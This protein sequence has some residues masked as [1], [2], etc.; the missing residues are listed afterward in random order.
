MRIRFDSIGDIAVIKGDCIDSMKSN[1]RVILERNPRLRVVLAKKSKVDGL[2]RL[3]E[4][5]RIAG[6]N[7]TVTIHRENGCIFHI[8]LSLVHF[9]P[10]LAHERML[11]AM[12]VKDGE[13]VLNMFGGVGTFS[14]EIAKMVTAKVF[15]VDI[16]PD[17]VRLCLTNILSNYVRGGVTTILADA[18]ES[19]SIFPTHTFDRILLP[20]PGK[21]ID[22]LPLAI[23][24]LKS[25]GVIHLYEFINVSR[26]EDPVEG[27]LR[28]VSLILGR[29][30]MLTY[31][32]RIVKSVGPRRYMVSL[33][34]VVE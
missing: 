6:E 3:C 4:Y 15:T 17:A 7:R 18:K 10:R 28:K 16:N 24:Y 30:K 5:I 2:F 1:A 31:E 9:S 13:I 33:E 20:L 32:G 21:S 22:Y 25:N 12:K 29:Q 34:I 14:I 27:V 23:P 11:V 26:K 19:L 8:D